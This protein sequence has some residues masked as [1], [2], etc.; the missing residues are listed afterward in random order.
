MELCNGLP[1]ICTTFTSVIN[2]YIYIMNTMGI[3]AEGKGNVQRLEVQKQKLQVISENVNSQIK[4][5]NAFESKVNKLNRELDT[6][7]NEL[8]AL[9]AFS[10][11]IAHDIRS[12][13]NSIS[14]IAHLIRSL[15]S[16]NKTLEMT[17]HADKIEKQVSRLNS[18]IDDL[19]LFSHQDIILEKEKVDMVK[20]VNEVVEDLKFSYNL[21]SDHK[22]SVY[23][24]PTVS[25]NPGL[26]R[27]VWTNLISNAIKYS[28]RTEKPVVKIGC[29]NNRKQPEFW[30]KDNGIGFK[31]SG[32]TKLFEL[33]SRMDSAKDYEGT[34]I[35]L[36]LCKR[37]IEKHGGKINGRSI[38]GKET[39]FSF[40]L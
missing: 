2:K 18:L 7:S 40:N 23:T 29:K 9:N 11:S 25:C 22:L 32:S 17:S 6:R 3:V 4:E 34:G 36:T 19:L 38:P 33:F 20:V 26:I 30:V 13:L 5:R 16:G 15:E 35:G 28:Q 14:M 31:E 37:I 27:Q 12:P 24:L 1:C 10:Y 8:E 39:I 21:T